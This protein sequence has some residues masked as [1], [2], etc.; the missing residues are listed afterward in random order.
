MKENL[1][2]RMK[3]ANLTP[4]ERKAIELLTADLGKTVFLSGA[5]MAEL[6][7]ISAASMTRLVR[8]LG[9]EKLTDFRDDLSLIYKRLVS[10][11]K[12]IENYLETD[13]KTEVMKK[14]LNK[15]LQNIETME[16]MLNTDILH[17]IVQ[18]LEKN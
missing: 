17:K 1:T 4:K 14:S 6:C 11:H 13:H 18:I 8:K 12:M 2:D 16:K 15:D 7:G 10:P 3:K 5:Q 9:Y